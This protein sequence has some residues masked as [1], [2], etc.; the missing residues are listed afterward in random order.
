MVSPN[1]TDRK[2]FWNRDSNLYYESESSGEPPAWSPD[3]SKLLVLARSGGD[4]DP[5]EILMV[6]ADGSGIT[7]VH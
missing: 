4:S 6:G 3:S 5:L 7:R 2:L 1:G